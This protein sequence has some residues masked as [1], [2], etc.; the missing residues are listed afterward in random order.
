MESYYD[1][2][3]GGC[4]LRHR[5]RSW[6]PV[7]EGHP[8]RRPG[9]DRRASRALLSDCP[10]VCRL[11]GAGPPTLARRRRRCDPGRDRR[12]G[13]RPGRSPGDR[14]RRPGRRGRRPRR[15]QRTI[16]P[17]N[18]SSLLLLDVAAG[19]WS[20]ELLD[21]FG[22]EPAALG[23]LRPATEV[24]GTLRADLAAAW[25]IPPCAVLVGSGDEH[26]ACVAAGV[27]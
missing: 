15:G 10:P 6:H 21:A 27:L 13:R 11:G 7:D 3:R 22:I 5:L 16:D 17:T 12:G 4:H 23:E 9:T 26:A 8:A 1:S 19:A 24:A 18:A 14:G 2:S 25:G 20:T